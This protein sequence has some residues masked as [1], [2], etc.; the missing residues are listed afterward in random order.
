MDNAVCAIYLRKVKALE[1]IMSNHPLHQPSAAAIGKPLSNLSSN[2]AAQLIHSFYAY[3][4]YL[5]EI[6]GRF[7]T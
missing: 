2:P 5:C 7:K 4:A 6:P 3:I 1:G